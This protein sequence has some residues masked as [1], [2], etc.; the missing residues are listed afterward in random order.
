MTTRLATG[1]LALALLFP[2]TTGAQSEAIAEIRVH[3][4]HTTPDGDVLALS[5]LAPG[6]PADAASL[7]AAERALRESGRFEDVEV[8]R[9]FRSIADPSQILVILV[10]DERPGVTEDNLLP[11]PM[12]RLR[13]A[14]M[15]VPILRRTDGYGTTYGA[16]AAFAGALGEHSRLSVPLTWG[17]ERRAALELERSF[18]DA[19]LVLRGALSES[20]RVNP[21]FELPDRRS[22]ARVEVSHAI[23]SW[24]RTGAAASVAQVRFGDAHDARHTTV[25]PTLTLDTRI[26]PSF[27]RNAVYARVGWERV[28]FGTG[29]AGRWRADLRGYAGLVGSTVLAIRGQLDRADAPLPLAEQPLLGGSDTLRGYHAGHQ[30]GDSLATLSAEIRHPLSSPLSAGRFGVKAFIDTGATWASGERLRKQQF[31]HGIGGGVYLGI[32][33]F[34]LDVD[35]A[36]PESGSPRTHVGMGVSF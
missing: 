7:L 15:W 16:Q 11:G 27:P 12:T 8:R 5:G 1:T 36:W 34:T 23:L 3:G 19:D 17:G 18:A 4:N 24:L 33:A 29:E 30:A 14:T 21:H 10:V 26:D 28:S 13:A 9:R 2:A 6:A 20:R 25:G 22:E 35:V 32:A 31:D